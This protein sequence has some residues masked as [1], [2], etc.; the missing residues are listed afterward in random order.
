MSDEV[1]IGAHTFGEFYA[2]GDDLSAVKHI[3]GTSLTIPGQARDLGALLAASK[4][5]GGMLPQSGRPHYD[6]DL[7]SGT[8][9][10]QFEELGDDEISAIAQEVASAEAEKEKRSDDDKAKEDDKPD[11]Q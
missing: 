6:D 4:F 2:L 1:K 8:A 9:R 10:M 3:N 7:A 5:Q 11:E